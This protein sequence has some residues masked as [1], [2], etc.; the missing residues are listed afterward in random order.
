[1]AEFVNDCQA[2]LFPDFGIVAADGFDI[3]LIE[4]GMQ[5]A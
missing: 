1:M 3:L 4:H 2:N 5:S